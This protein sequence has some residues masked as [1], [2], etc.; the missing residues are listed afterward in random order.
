MII[1]SSVK[2]LIE[3][4]PVAIATVMPN[5]DPN[6]IGVAYVKV[7]DDQIIV[8]NN[9]MNQ[10][11]KDIEHNPHVAVIVWNQNLEGYKIIGEA[12]HFQ[13]GEWMDFVKNIP[14]NKNMPTKGALVITVS[15]VISSA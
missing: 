11:L 8:T 5:G 1:P 12:K 6:V 7:V 2:Q 13:E 14:E 15:K 10:T 9:F 4:T 3:S